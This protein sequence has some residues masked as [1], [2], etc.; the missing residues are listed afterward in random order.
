VV[1]TAEMELVVAR[2]GE[3]HSGSLWTCADE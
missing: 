1:K 2:A 3:H